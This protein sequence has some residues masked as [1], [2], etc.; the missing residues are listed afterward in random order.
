M[1]SLPS[2][3]STLEKQAG[4]HAPVTKNKRAV[5]TESLPAKR[6]KSCL[7]DTE[8][9][10]RRS[11]VVDD[12]AIKTE[13]GH[14]ITDETDD[15][16]DDEFVDTG[17]SSV[18]IRVDDA[19]ELDTIIDT[20]LR[21]MQQTSCK[22]VARTWI[23]SYEPQKQTKYPYNGGILKEEVI[24]QYG[25]KNLGELT[26]PPWWPSTEGWPNNGGCRHREPDHLKKPGMLLLF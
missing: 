24:R 11:R 17:Y 5:S 20:R 10:L 14:V 26:K 8:Q 3:S 4:R 18:A 16:D 22:S 23:K 15:S 7:K 6:R 9:L 19:V 2:Q 12:D 13:Q 1:D 25:D 21:Q